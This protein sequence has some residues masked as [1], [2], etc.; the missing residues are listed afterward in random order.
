MRRSRFSV[1]PV[2][3]SSAPPRGPPPRRRSARSGAHPRSS[4][5]TSVPAVELHDDRG[6]RRPA[7]PRT[8]GFDARSGRQ[9]PV[10]RRPLRLDRFQHAIGRETERTSFRARR[11]RLGSYQQ[12]PSAARESAEELPHLLVASITFRRRPECRGVALG[13]HQRRRRR[14][15]GGTAVAAA[16]CFTKSSTAM[17]GDARVGAGK[18]GPRPPP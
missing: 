17:C 3:R 5:V 4:P 14:R 15:L 11:P 8:R 12:P 2:P 16:Q 6:A 13:A 9:R 7:R 1:V 18:G 10:E